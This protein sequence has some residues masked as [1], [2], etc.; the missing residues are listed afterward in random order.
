MSTTKARVGIIG[1]RGYTGA[2]LVKLLDDHP[3]LEIGLVTSREL[4]GRRLCDVFPEVKSELAFSSPSPDEAVGTGIDRWILALPNG[5][6]AP[7]VAAIERTQPESIVV[8]LSTD[9][10]FDGGWTYGLPEIGRAHLLGARRI[11]NPGCYATAAQLALYPLL[12]DLDGPASVFGISG[13][14]GAG[15]TPSPRNDPARL[16][17]NVLPYSLSGHAHETEIRWQLG[18]KVFFSPIVASFFRGLVVTVH[19][20]LKEGLSAE[21]LLVRYRHAYAYEPLVRV[22]VDPPEPREA[23]YN[24]GCMVGGFAAEI[25]ERHVV[26]CAALDNLLKGAAT[27]A[28]QNLN[29]ASGLDEL[30]GVRHHLT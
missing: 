29:L 17:D 21:D 16:A 5:Q 4:T 18:H 7:W 13:Y 20:T 14:S 12:G 1:A 30:A 27:Q 10:R 8:D 24:H 6:S 3:E 28:I 22:R 19:A 26:V 25:T 23:A 2:E 11:A 9:H 15:T